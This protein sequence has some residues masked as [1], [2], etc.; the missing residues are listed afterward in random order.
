M[1]Y[2]I[3][4]SIKEL[5]KAMIKTGIKFIDPFIDHKVSELNGEKVPSFG[6]S[7]VGY[8]IR[9]ADEVQSIDNSGLDYITEEAGQKVIRLRAYSSILIRSEEYFKIPEDVFGLI[10]GKSTYTRQGVVLNATPIEPGWAGNLTLNV[11]NS[12]PRTV[13]L[14]IGA[15][16]AQVQFIKIPFPD[17][18]Y[19][20]HSRYQNSIGITQAYNDKSDFEVD[21]GGC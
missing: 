13:D 16:I 15:G 14:I 21:L 10:Y 7:S 4:Y 9:L 2:L 3:D 11:N 6:L 8:D 20:A 1:T 5:Q 18:A 12:T 19:G 17:T